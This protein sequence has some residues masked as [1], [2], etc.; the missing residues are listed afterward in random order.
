M[1]AVQEEE[2]VCKVR[3]YGGNKSSAPITVDEFDRLCEEPDLGN[4][5]F[6]FV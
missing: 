2:N 4:I 6:Q 1:T 3:F 5:G